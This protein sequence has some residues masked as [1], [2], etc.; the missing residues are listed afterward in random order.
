MT[1]PRNRGDELDYGDEIVEMDWIIMT[2]ICTHHA[3]LSPNSEWR[4][5]FPIQFFAL[6]SISLVGSIFP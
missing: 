1:E 3:N 4:R 2:N 6:Q 5:F